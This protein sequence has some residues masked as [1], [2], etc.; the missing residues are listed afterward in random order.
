MSNNIKE[1]L[2]YIE[3]DQS[4]EVD[5]TIIKYKSS[6]HITV[7]LST[8]EGELEIDAFLLPIL[9]DFLKKKNYVK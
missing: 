1:E 5:A 4:M 3:L 8:I 7:K 9:V 6:G 2:D